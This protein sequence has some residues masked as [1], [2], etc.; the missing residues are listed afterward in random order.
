[1]ALK[2]LLPSLSDDGE[3]IARFRR[4]AQ[5][6]SQLRHPNVI[7]VYN[8]GEDENNG[9]HFMAMEYIPGGS[10]QTRL[11][12][13]ATH[14]ERMSEREVLTTTRQLASALSYAHSK[15]YVHRDI[16][17]SN[18]LLRA[19][20]TAV[21]ADFGIVLATSGTKLT[22]TVSAIGTP[23]YMS[24]EQAQGKRDMDARSD[25][26]SLGIVMYEML[27]GAPPFQSESPISV[28]YQQI[29]EALPNIAR[30]RKGI[31]ITTRRII[32]RATRK[33][34]RERFQSADE[35][36]NALDM[37]LGDAHTSV[38]RS[39]GV[40]L[41]LVKPTSESKAVRA[42]GA[43]G[44]CLLRTLMTLLII[45]A[46]TVVIVSGLVTI[47]GSMALER[48]LGSYQWNWRYAFN[49]ERFIPGSDFR[50]NLQTQLPAYTLNVV[51]FRDLALDAPD[52]INISANM[53]QFV[54]SIAFQVNQ[55]GDVPELSLVSV[56]DSPL[57]IIG[58]QL[59]AGINRGLATSWRNEK[60]RL[61]DIHVASD[62]IT[63]HAEALPG[64]D[65][66]LE[67]SVTA[68]PYRQ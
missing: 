38:F 9:V 31:S 59:S 64:Y 43:L 42:A 61:I 28:A 23:E 26:Y 29:G 33:N 57:P 8:L 51:Q 44:G 19:D 17:P 2:V 37:A 10:L 45:V 55:N 7:E 11:K 62:G 49:G 40:T 65:P 35:L 14:G 52:R 46:V 20:G 56:N 22:S 25:I 18:V 1:V 47:G 6:A 3:F 63:T 60:M 15:G 50:T 41:G 54:I 30:T 68:T 24:P 32:E 16:K 67:P 13:L 21:L 36:I 58:D 66:A 53:D 4:E 27:A 34:P 39:L 12:D 48:I 5:A